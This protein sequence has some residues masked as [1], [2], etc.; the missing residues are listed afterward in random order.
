MKL[1]PPRILTLEEAIEFIN[2]DELV[3]ITPTDIRVRKKYLTE[4]DRRRHARELGK[5]ED[6]SND[7]NTAL[8]RQMEAQEET[9]KSAGE[10]IGKYET[11][12]MKY[13]ACKS[14][15]EITRFLQMN[16]DGFDSLGLNIKTAADAMDVFVKRTPQM[17]AALMQISVAKG[18]QK[19]LEEYTSQWAT[20]QAKNPVRLPVVN[21]G[22][23]FRIQ[24]FMSGKKDFR[25][26][27]DQS[28]LK[29]AGIT[30]DMM[31]DVSVPTRRHGSMPPV[32][33]GLGIT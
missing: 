12:R 3:E 31:T 11:L 6:G 18:A 10:L 7:L 20:A 5:L 27:D 24:S 1:V 26:D 32:L 16:V 23:R 2:D 17:R 22:T 9:G 28:W 29:E 25:Y 13:L 14:D 19:A 21:S 8:G 33:S 30:S 4:I 15:M